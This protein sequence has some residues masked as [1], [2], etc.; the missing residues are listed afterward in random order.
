MT[1][2]QVFTQNDKKRI[3]AALSLPIKEME[4]NSTLE[5]QMRNLEERDERNNGATNLVADVQGF[6]TAIDTLNTAIAASE[7]SGDAELRSYT[8]VGEVATTYKIDS[9]KGAG[10]DRLRQ[11]YIARIA[12][13]LEMPRQGARIL[14]S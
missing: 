1:L 11:N 8:I 7:T 10:S 4:E 3:F 2:F 12:Q 14:R 6:L 13:Y 5:A 9:Y